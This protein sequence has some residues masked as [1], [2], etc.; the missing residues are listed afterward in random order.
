MM[1]TARTSAE[2]GRLETMLF[3]RPVLLSRDYAA[4]HVQRSRID[5]DVLRGDLV[6]Q[7]FIEYA[8]YVRQEEGWTLARACACPLETFAH[9]DGL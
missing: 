9:G 2:H 6:G 3:E 5:L 7:F 8:G 4:G 1:R